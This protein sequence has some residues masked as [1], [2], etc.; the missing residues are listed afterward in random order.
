MMENGHCFVNRKGVFFPDTTFWNCLSASLLWL[1]SVHEWKQSDERNMKRT[2]LV[3]HMWNWAES[4]NCLMKEHL[5]MHWDH[6]LWRCS[7]SGLH[8]CLW[9]SCCTWFVFDET[10]H[11]NPESSKW[12]FLEASWPLPWHHHLG[13]RCLCENLTMNKKTHRR[14]AERTNANIQG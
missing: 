9:K 14:G 4:M 5:Q 3:S 1:A 6:H 13:H 10:N 2:V 8:W 7:L 12:C 11:S